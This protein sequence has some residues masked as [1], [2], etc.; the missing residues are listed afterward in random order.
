VPTL[1]TVAWVIVCVVAGNWQR[2]RMAG[3]EMLAA[4]LAA[5]Q[6]AP[7]IPLPDLGAGGDWTG[8]R[9]RPV[10]LTGAFDA[11]RQ[12]Y[13]DNR[14]HAGRVGYEVVAPFV[15]ADR[16]IVLVDRGWIAQGAS[17]A[18]LP[19]ADPPTGDVTV[20]GRIETP[21]KGYLELKAESNPGP[22]WQHLD[23]ARFAAATGLAV[24]PIVVEESETPARADGLARDR[25][26][27]DLGIEMHKSYMIQWYTFGGLAV[28]FWV[29]LTWRARKRSG[30]GEDA[31]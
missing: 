24:L 12:I 14:V 28:F 3:K 21:A 2:E 17:R 31:R 6:K 19:K 26:P 23:P 10:E 4:Q 5:A 27:P 16:R 8:L 11:A 30:G 13:I 22:V 1:A 15:L 20:D 7:P 9:Y 25:A 18:Q 29:W